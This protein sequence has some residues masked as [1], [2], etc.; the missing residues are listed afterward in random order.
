MGLAQ[1]VGA[2]NAVVTRERRRVHRLDAHRGLGETTDA[3]AEHGARRGGCGRVGRRWAAVGEQGEP[4]SGAVASA[5][6]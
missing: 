2:E 1:T 4:R 3:S 5:A 6:R